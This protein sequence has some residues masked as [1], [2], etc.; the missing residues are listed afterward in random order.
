MTIH[1][2][3]FLSCSDDRVRAISL[4][5]GMVPIIWTRTDAAGQFD[6]NDWKVAGG[7]VTGPDSFAAFEAILGNASTMDTGFIVLEHDLYQVTVDLAIGYTLSAAQT[8]NP[9]FAVSISF[10][11]LCCVAL[12]WIWFIDDLVCVQIKPIG[13]CSKIPATN[14][15]AETNRNASFPY[16]NSTNSADNI[17]SKSNSSASSN[18]TSGA[19]SRELGGGGWT[20]VLSLGVGV[21]VAGMHAMFL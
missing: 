20:G 6:T 15:Y 7:M 2:L 5:M 19:L 16:S 3:T 17:S 1:R 21:V 8:H 12:G 11:P 13:N 4:A 10:I 14:L 9:S 18:S